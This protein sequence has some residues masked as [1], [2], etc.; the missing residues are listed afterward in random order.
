MTE[1]KQVNRIQDI[2]EVPPVE[3]E[4]SP[5]MPREQAE[6]RH[7]N[8]STPGKEP[9]RSGIAVSVPSMEMGSVAPV[10]AVSLEKG[11]PQEVPQASRIGTLDTVIR[12][13][14]KPVEIDPQLSKE[15]DRVN[16]AVDPVNQVLKREDLE[17]KPVEV[18]ERAQK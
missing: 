18:E 7:A 17:V 9:K 3:V 6:L 4:K 5:E 15:V 1:F 10:P 14:F 16:V 11:S 12:K 2:R 8:P 13:R